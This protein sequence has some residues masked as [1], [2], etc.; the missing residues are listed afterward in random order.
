MGSERAWPLVNLSGN[1]TAD[2]I[3][4]APSFPA[5]R[6]QG[7]AYIYQGSSQFSTTP[8]VVLTGDSL[9]Y[10]LG[11]AC[12]IG[13]LNN[14]GSND[15]AI[16]GLFQYGADSARWHYVDI[17]YGGTTFDTTRSLRFRNQFGVWGDVKI[18][19][20]NG[21]HIPDLLWS[22][23]DTARTVFVH[24]GRKDFTAYPT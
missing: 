11:I 13:D 18:F 23:Y 7:R 8:K 19:D 1:S 3:V 15:L 20:V 2:L 10:G 5:G 14:D 6:A 9:R 4:C 24:Y 21:D 16:R 22:T 17:W 12:A